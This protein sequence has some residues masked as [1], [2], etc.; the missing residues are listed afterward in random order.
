[1]SVITILSDFGTDDE[2]V[3]VMKGV[4]LSVCPSVSIVDITHQIDPQDIPQAA[5][6]LTSYYHFFPER[7]VHIVVVDPG[8]GSQ[9]NILA[10]NHREHFFIAPDNGVLTLLLNAE[11]SDTII[12]VVNS[13]YFLEPLSSTFHGRDIFAAVGAHV[14]CGTKLDEF[15]ARINYKDIVRLEDLNCRISESGELIGK[16]ISID[17]FGNLIAN[18]DSISLNA[19]CQT[20]PLKRPQIRIGCFV[21]SGLS[22]TYTDAAPAAPLALIGS[23]SYLEIAVNGG[24]A[25]ENLKAQKGDQIRVTLS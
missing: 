14:S 16:I 4:M 9:R 11:K 13:D 25:K 8:V 12:G 24:N 7:T 3:G 5:Y 18:I 20:G 17:R 10:V 22:N 2:Y 19:F 21:I 6:L 15:G 23:R 1:M